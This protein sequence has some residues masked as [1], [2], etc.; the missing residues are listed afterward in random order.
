MFRLEPVAF[1]LAL[2]H[3][4]GLPPIADL[5]LVCGHAPV[6]GTP[7][8]AHAL[9]CNQGGFATAKHNAL[10]RAW[11]YVLRLGGANVLVGGE[12]APYSSPGDAR[13]VDALVSGVPGLAA[14][15]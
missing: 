6:A 1:V 13:R 7:N 2:R 15:T 8:W 12:F 3:Y 11:M 5:P 9:S 10:G 4:V 14:E